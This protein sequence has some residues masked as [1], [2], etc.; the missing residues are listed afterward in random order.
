M[1]AEFRNAKAATAWVPTT[2]GVVRAVSPLVALSAPVLGLLFSK[3][4]HYDPK[5]E[6]ERDGKPKGVVAMSLLA[7]ELLRKAKPFWESFRRLGK[8]SPRKPTTA[9]QAPAPRS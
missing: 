7:F 3:K 4:K 9:P 6:G 1:M 8:R 5:H 2:I